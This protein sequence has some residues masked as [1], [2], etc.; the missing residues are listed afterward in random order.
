M[1]GSGKKIKGCKFYP[2]NYA[3]FYFNLLCFPKER[4]RVVWHLVS[5][6]PL[7]HLTSSKFPTRREELRLSNSRLLI[8]PRNPHFKKYNITSDYAKLLNKRDIRY[9]LEERV[10]A[11]FGGEFHVGEEYERWGIGSE[12][13]K[14]AQWKSRGE[15]E[16]GGLKGG[17]G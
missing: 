15:S 4:K 7:G 1:R 16:K 10:G 3:D 8:F 14:G 2:T 17:G 6:C 11:D 9:I 5:L 13:S 12:R